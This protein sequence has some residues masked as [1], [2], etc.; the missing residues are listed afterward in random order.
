[1]AAAK[2]SRHNG[3]METP[4]VILAAGLGMRRRSRQAKVLHRA[5][6]K[7]LIE[8]VAATALELAPAERIFLVAG[9]QANAVRRT[10][11]TPGS[12]SSNRPRPD[13]TFLVDETPDLYPRVLVLE[14]DA[15]A[16]ASI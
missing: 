12:V 5:G 7:T 4:V 6:G 14:T 13:L 3:V 2:V 8:H 1:M 15:V 9:Y 11:A 10:V 16:I